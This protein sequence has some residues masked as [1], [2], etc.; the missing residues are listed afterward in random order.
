MRLPV[1]VALAALLAIAEG[2]E[3]AEAPEA[4]GALQVE[5]A[6]LERTLFCKP[7]Q[8]VNLTGQCPEGV[9]IV[10]KVVSPTRDFKLNKAGKGLGLVWV[11]AGHAEIKEIPAMY[12]ILS[13][14]K[15]SAVLSPAEREAAGLTLDFKEVYDQAK[16]RF[17]RDPPPNMSA[18]LRK[19]FISGLLTIFREEGLY[20][21]SETAVRINGCQFK[22]QFLLPTGAPLG[23]YNVFCYAVQDGKVRLLCQE[24]FLVRPGRLIG[25][26]AYHAQANPE[27]YGVLAA[28]IAV[29]AGLL[30][31]VVFRK[32]AR[33]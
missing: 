19:E 8:T 3:A 17:E 10:L 1:L 2:L 32:G 25:W 21:T 27:I 7:F 28:L 5:P 13:S 14:A 31:G 4:S 33:H 22:A 20:Q 6:V 15:I 24:K 26:L 16:V 12:A 9:Q 18:D 23:D 11:P 29:L 30:V